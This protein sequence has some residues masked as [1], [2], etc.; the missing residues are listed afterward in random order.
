MSTDE[1]EPAA[2]E[3]AA[4]EAPS[5]P[6][7]EPHVIA[8]ATKWGWLPKDQ[9]TGEPGRWSDPGRYLSHPMTQ[10]RIL[11]EEAKAKDERLA[12]VERATSA[13]LAEVRRQEREAAEERVAAIRAEKLAAVES[14]DL[15]RYKELEEIER[16][17]SQPRQQQPEIPAEVTAYRASE[18]GK[19]LDEPGMVEFAF[20][21]IQNS[22]EAL[23]MGPAQQMEFAEGRFKQRFAPLFK[24]PEPEAQ[25]D[26]HGRFARVDDGGL[27]SGRRGKSIADL[28]K[29]A[30]D[31]FR[32]FKAEGVKITEAQYVRDYLGEA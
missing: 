26:Q 31:A 17:V 22:P 9:F 18:R 23:K 6:G 5:E 19:W 16:R 15:D 2:P 7:Y 13:T 21:A 27:A 32:M 10:V 8:E 1:F 20:N 4:P 28:P 12:A 11:R 3:A 25:R 29:E 14:S 24:A 30:Q